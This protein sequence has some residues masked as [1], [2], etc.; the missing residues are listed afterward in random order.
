M[1]WEDRKSVQSQKRNPSEGN[2]IIGAK[3][4]FT[5]TDELHSWAMTQLTAALTV[6]M[7]SLKQSASH[8]EHRLLV[9]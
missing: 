9:K 4:P 1:E 3:C 7:Q 2:Q 8:C 5:V 6:D